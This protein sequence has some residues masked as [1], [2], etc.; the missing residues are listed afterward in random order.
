MA[1]M[2]ISVLQTLAVSR[3]KSLDALDRRI[4]ALQ[5][6][7]LTASPNMAVV[8]VRMIKVSE[9]RR[10]TIADELKAILAEIERLQ[11]S[12]PGLGPSMPA[13]QG[14]PQPKR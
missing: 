7:K 11:P 10:T 3:Q 8:Y 9:Q 2:D 4:S 1:D 5:S 13:G 6:Y 14:K 12:L